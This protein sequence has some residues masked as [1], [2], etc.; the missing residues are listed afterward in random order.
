MQT[1][2]SLL[3]VVFIRQ[4]ER[5]TDRH[6]ERE[7]GRERKRETLHYVAVLQC[8]IE[9]R[10]YGTAVEWLVKACDLPVKSEVGPRESL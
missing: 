8:Y 3:G 4:T 9:K 1:L 2:W 7:R 6:R 10:D 5:Q